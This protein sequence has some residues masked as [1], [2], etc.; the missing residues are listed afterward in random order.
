MIIYYVPNVPQQPDPLVQ[1]CH[2]APGFVP[3]FCLALTETEEL[4]NTNRE[5]E[6]VRILEH[7]CRRACDLIWTRGLL[8][9]GVGLCHGISGNAYTFLYMHEYLNRNKR[10]CTGLYLARAVAFAQVA[11]ERL[12]ELM[13]VPD[14]PY[15]LF[16][17]VL[18]LACLYMDIALVAA[19]LPMV[20][21][22]TCERQI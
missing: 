21:F 7:V 12:E 20:G 19:G 17:G 2:G 22:P 9:K 3:L 4:S 18:G 5:R 15:S 14:H 8:R 6:R 13:D 11:T 10:R 16:E 1:W